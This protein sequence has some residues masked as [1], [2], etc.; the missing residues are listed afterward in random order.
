MTLLVPID[1]TDPSVAA[2]SLAASLGAALGHELVLLHVSETPPPL[3]VLAALHRLG[4]PARA[5]GVPVRLRL[6]QGDP[7]TVVCEQAQARGAAWIVMGTRG[8]PLLDADP[9]ASLAGSVMRC[10][11]V[12]VVAV[13]PGR[14]DGGAPLA[15]VD[16][17]AAVVRELGLVLADARGLR[18]LACRPLVEG[19]PPW[20]PAEGRAPAAWGGAVIAF[21]PDCEGLAWCGR[22]LQETA[23]DVVLVSHG[24]C[25]CAEVAAPP[26]LG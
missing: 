3:D 12:P 14:P 5:R 26:G 8:G 24:P 10:A 21:S 22:V 15:V 4:E 25:G 9:G 17:G 2:V 11:P 19:T 7:R 1:P 16:G 23:G 6:A 20:T 18:P 13:R